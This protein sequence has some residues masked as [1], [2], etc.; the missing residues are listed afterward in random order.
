LGSEVNLEI[1]HHPFSNARGQRFRQR[2]WGYGGM[3]ATNFGAQ[4]KFFEK[5]PTDGATQFGNRNHIAI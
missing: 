4:A 2:K 3:T 5:F 1:L